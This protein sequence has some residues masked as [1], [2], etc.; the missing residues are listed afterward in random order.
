MGRQ[1][2]LLLGYK[3]FMDFNI[4][5]QKRTSLVVQWLGIHLL[6]QQTLVQSLVREDSTCGEAT[7]PM[8]PDY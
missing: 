3:D 4:K 1:S 7:K 6:M 5:K 8:C 2:S